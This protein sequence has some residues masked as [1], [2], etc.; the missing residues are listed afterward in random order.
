MAGSFK[1]AISK[2]GPASGEYITLSLHNLVPGMA[3][4]FEVMVRTNLPGERSSQ[5][6]TCSAPGQIFEAHWLEKLRDAGVNRVYCRRR[7]QDLVFGYLTP[8]PGS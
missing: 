7:D 2:A 5:F 8:S 4:P 6:K 3:V 1:T